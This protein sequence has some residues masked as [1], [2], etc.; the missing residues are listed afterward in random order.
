MEKRN[1]FVL[2]LNEFNHEQLQS[3]D[4]AHECEFHSLFSYEEA[5][6]G[7]KYPVPDMLSMAR[8]QLRKFSGRVDGVISLWD[9]PTSL[10]APILNKEFTGR[11]KDLTPLFKCENKYWSRM[12]QRKIVPNLI[13]DF[14]RFD[15]FAD[16]PSAAITLEY[17]FWVKPIKSFGSYLAFLVRSEAELKTAIQNMRGG[18]GHLQAG[19]DH[20]MSHVKIPRA[21]ESDQGFAIAESS[22]S[23]DWQC[24]LEGYVHQGSFNIHGVVDSYCETEYESFSRYQYPSILPDDVQKRMIRATQRVLEHFGFDDSAFNIEFYWNRED[25]SLRLLEI[26]PRVSQSHAELFNKVDGSPNLQITTRIA[27]GES[28]R[29][30]RS[31][32]GF[33]VAAKFFVRWYGDGVVSSAPDDNTVRRIEAE[34]PGSVIQVQVKRGQRLEKLPFQDSYSSVLALMFI[35]GETTE[36]LEDKYALCVEKLGFEVQV[37]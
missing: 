32:G 12:E 36:E 14:C 22:I 9:Y 30:T 8:D 15:P 26:N 17:P 28:P 6:G 5:H 18:I 23:T 7:R 11:P 35:G 21:I 25:D 3:I 19:F 29:F 33:P 34:V 1:I 27:L 2:G 10:M 4:K 20:L 13:P 16:D 31:G 37:K 24:T